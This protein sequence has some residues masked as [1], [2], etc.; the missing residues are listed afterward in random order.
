MSAPLVMT[1]ATASLSQ[2]A[3][4]TLNSLQFIPAESIGDIVN[5][6]GSMHTNGVPP[7]IARSALGAWARK[8]KPE[9]TDGDIGALWAQSASTPAVAAMEPEPVFILDSP[10]AAAVL[11][12]QVATA[13]S[14]EARERAKR[15]SEEKERKHADVAAEHRLTTVAGPSDTPDEHFFVPALGCSDA[16][17]GT[18]VTHP[19]TELGNAHRLYDKHKG[20]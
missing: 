13:S 8:T 2:A 10:A 18:A 7:D 1:N 14:A 6:C 4:N 15:A 9:V 17:D 3:Q 20:E 5:L 19:L 12:K 11:A 16:R